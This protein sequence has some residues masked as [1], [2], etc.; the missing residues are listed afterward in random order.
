MTIQ[1]PAICFTII[2][3]NCRENFEVSDENDDDD[4]DDDQNDGM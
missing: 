1:T 2:N 4:D 3:V